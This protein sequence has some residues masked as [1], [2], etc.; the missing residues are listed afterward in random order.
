M[1]NDK[2]YIVCRPCHDEQEKTGE[3]TN[4]CIGLAKHYVDPWY[5]VQ[6]RNSLDK[7]FDNHVSCG[8]ESRHEKY[9]DL[10]THF[11]LEYESTAAWRNRDWPGHHKEES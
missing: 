2:M 1:A 5:V 4:F 7:F 10:G 8:M 9:E 11:T 3:E 6:D